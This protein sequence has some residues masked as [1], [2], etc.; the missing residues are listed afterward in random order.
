MSMPMA[1]L[2]QY[3]KFEKIIR[4]CRDRKLIWLIH[5]YRRS[6]SSQVFEKQPVRV[7]PIRGGGFGGQTVRTTTIPH[8]PPIV[9]TPVRGSATATLRSGGSRKVTSPMRPDIKADGTAQVSGLGNGK[10]NL[11]S[12]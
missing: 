11:V 7:T 5:K 3:V 9:V 4:V 12:T 2:I 10:Y 1:R 8:G 6:I